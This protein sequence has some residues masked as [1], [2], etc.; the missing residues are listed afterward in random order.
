[1]CEMEKSARGREDLALSFRSPRP[2]PGDPAR[3]RP[4]SAPTT[5][6]FFTH[7]RLNSYLKWLVFDSRANGIWRC[8]FSAAIVFGTHEALPIR[9]IGTPGLK[10]CDT[11]KYGR[12]QILTWTRS[13]LSQTG[14]G[15]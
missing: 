15:C 7:G 13:C 10:H 14:A 9:C 5:D 1:M 11:H 2:R 8:N 12:R 4:T 6:F 3:A